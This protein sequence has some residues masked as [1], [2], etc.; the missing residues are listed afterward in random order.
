MLTDF[1]QRCPLLYPICAP[2][3]WRGSSTFAMT[4]LTDEKSILESAQQT[5]D[6]A[7][8]AGRPMTDAERRQVREKLDRATALQKSREADADDQELRRK[9]SHAF[10]GTQQPGSSESLRFDAKTATAHL[11][12]KMTP[13]GKAIA[14]S[15]AEVAPSG[16]TLP[17]PIEMPI[18]V[19]GLLAVVP[20]ETVPQPPLVSYLKQ[21]ARAFAAAVVASG[22]QKPTT[23]MGLT[24]VEA[25]LSVV[26][27]ISEPI[28]RF[29]LSDSASVQMWVSDELLAAVNQAVEA[30]IVS[31]INATSGV[32]VQ[33]F[34][35]DPAETLRKA[36]TKVQ[37]MGGST[38]IAALNPADWEAICLLREA[39]TNAFLGTDAVTMTVPGG[40]ASPPFAPSLLA[41]WG[42]PVALSNAVPAGSAFVFD[43][44]AIRLFT[45]AVLAV[46]W[47]DG[48]GGF[49]KNLVTGRAEGRFHVGVLK[50]ILV[51]KTDVSAA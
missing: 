15:G 10:G 13:Q 6:Q 21:N 7:K 45:D 28:D 23:T 12:E 33:A 8:Q 51:V 50:P 27:T 26:A 1:G 37:Q 19:N 36:L 39:T 48:N 40:S 43:S 32:Q 24:R 16:L 38:A 31:T 41:S 3:L 35:T 49:E 47:S 42:M 5:I 14:P 34:S 20:A 29:W 4:T 2:C 17:A 22:A 11:T 44:D 18:P 9:L 25:A 30:L 46:D